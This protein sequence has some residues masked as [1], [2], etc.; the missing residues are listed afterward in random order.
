MENIYRSCYAWALRSFQM[1]PGPL[2]RIN[3]HIGSAVSLS[4]FQNLQELWNRLRKAVSCKRGSGR[5]S[6]RN[7][8]QKWA[9]LHRLIVKILTLQC[10]MSLDKSMCCVRSPY[11][12][13]YVCIQCNDKYSCHLYGIQYL[14]TSSWELCQFILF[15]FFRLHM[16]FR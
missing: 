3:L 1:F 7:C 11:L 12:R 8:V 6:K 14:Q 16:V 5:H 4:E 15:Y 13:W 10:V 9:D 2:F